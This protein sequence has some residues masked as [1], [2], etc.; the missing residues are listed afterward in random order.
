M[1]KDRARIVATD[2]PRFTARLVVM[3][4]P[5]VVEKLDQWSQENGRSLASEVRAAIR[6]WISAWEDR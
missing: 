5:A 3:E 6:Y 4:E 2:R 1:D